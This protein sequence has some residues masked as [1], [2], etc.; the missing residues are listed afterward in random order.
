MSSAMKSCGGAKPKKQAGHAD[1]FPS[2]HSSRWRGS[3]SLRAR[4]MAGDARAAWMS[5]AERQVS[6]GTGHGVTTCIGRA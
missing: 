3:G 4:A 5:S 1:Q 6:H 2:A